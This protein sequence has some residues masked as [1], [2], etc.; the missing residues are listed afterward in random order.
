MKQISMIDSY[1]PNPIYKNLFYHSSK[2]YSPQLQ[3]LGASGSVEE[4]D[5]N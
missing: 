5:T 3:Q 1:S 4:D 2:E